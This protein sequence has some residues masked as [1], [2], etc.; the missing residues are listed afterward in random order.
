MLNNNFTQIFV[1]Q[2]TL[3]MDASQVIDTYL[4][5][6]GLLNF[7]FAMATASAYE[8]GA[9]VVVAA[10]SQFCF[11]KI[12]TVGSILK[13]ACIMVGGRS[14]GERAFNISNI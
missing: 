5:Q 2:N 7:Q 13:E 9:C 14:H 3:N 8:V 10:R 1:F 4:Y 6:T 12:D 11:E